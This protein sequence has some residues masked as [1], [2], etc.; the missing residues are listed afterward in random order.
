MWRFESTHARQDSQYLDHVIAQLEADPHLFQHAE[1][2]LTAVSHQEPLV[3]QSL[4]TPQDVRYHAE[5]STMRDHL[6]LML[7]FLFALV[8]EKVH[9][10]DIEEFRRLKGYEGEIQELED[11]MKENIAFFQVFTLGHD[12]AK[13]V[14]TTFT[15]KPGSRGEALGF[16]TP[17]SHHFDEVAHE[18]AAKRDAY[19][20]L[21][22]EFSQREF[23]GTDRETQA[24]FYLQYGVSVHYPH[25]ARKIHAPVFEALLRRLC[26]AHRLP[27]RDGD[28]LEDLISHHM[29]CGFDFK[30]PRPVRIRRY[31]YIAMK[32][33]YDADDFIDLAQACL[34]LD[35]TIGSL[36]LSAHGYWHETKSFINF[37]Q[38]EH[39]FAPYRRA[40]K[41]ALRETQEKKE[42][43]RVLREVGLD[44]IAMM[45]V[46]GMESGP[47]FGLALRRI[48]AGV[49]GQGEMPRFGRKI[50]AE[51][52]KRAGAFYSK[53]FKRGE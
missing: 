39:D 8:E 17:R 49:S 27:D 6:R 48:H 18:H 23:H 3:V 33:G 36:R 34:L 53:M 9:L 41:E 22:K 4:L 46:L 10:V 11:L 29:E 32:R 14:T 50:N 24:Q 47:E 20:D 12:V 31:T 2:L 1:S 16:N 19:L 28:L 26:A 45:D 15:S 40:E 5:G 38:S 35:Q 30:V 25:H 51:I 21:Y 13:W 43:N 52:E 42:R 44:G 37:L 7:I